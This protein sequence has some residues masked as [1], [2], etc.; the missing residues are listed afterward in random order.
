MTNIDNLFMDNSTVLFLFGALLSIIGF[1]IAAYVRQ[2]VERFDKVE[3][4]IEKHDKELIQQR[5]K[6][7]SII[8]DY[9]VPINARML[10][11]EERFNAKFKEMDK[12]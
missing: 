11:L 3:K 2:L 5:E 8:S 7:H 12:L 4:Y 10:V 9:I 1:V 6:Y